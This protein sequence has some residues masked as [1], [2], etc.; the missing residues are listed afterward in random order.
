MSENYNYQIHQIMPCA[1]PMK[2]VFYDVDE[3]ELVREDVVCMAIIHGYD[4]NNPIPDSLV[5]PMI[6]DRHGDFYDP[7]G[8]DD[9]IGVEYNG[10]EENWDEEIREL[11]MRMEVANGKRGLN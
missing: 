6:G 1:V 4:G 5:V 9:F 7:C 10:K 3:E 11:E 2:I 8:Q